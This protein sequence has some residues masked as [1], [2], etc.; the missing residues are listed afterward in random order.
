MKERIAALL[1]S[2]PPGTLLT[3]A[4]VSAIVFVAS[5]IAIPFI[6]VRLPVDYFDVRVPRSWMKGKHPL[7]RTVG[8][9]VKNVA[10]FLFFLAGVS[11]LVLP[12]Q[13]VL[14]ILIGISLMDFP[15]KRRLEAWIIGRPLVL[16]VVNSLRARFGKPRFV[17]APDS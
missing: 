1:A 11:M 6:L 3:M 14:T 16:N 9:V 13:G 12:G 8:Q 2:L 4:I 17:L 7:F 5:L 15:G 10:G